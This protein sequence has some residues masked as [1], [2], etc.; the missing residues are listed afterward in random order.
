MGTFSPEPCS[1]SF[2]R[3]GRCARCDAAL[4]ASL[5]D[6]MS[7]HHANAHGSFCALHCPACRPAEGSL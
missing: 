2:T 6:P 7:A 5:H 1:I 3:R 4:G